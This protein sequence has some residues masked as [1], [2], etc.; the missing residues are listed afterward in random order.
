M[1]LPSDIALKMSVSVS[2]M[3]ISCCV[4]AY[5]SGV[6]LQNPHP[7]ETTDRCT[8]D[9]GKRLPDKRECACGPAETQPQVNL[10]MEHLP[11][12]VSGSSMISSLNA[13]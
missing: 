9:G 2:L 6:P 12:P 13:S 10:K 3:S 4:N 1:T 5:R 11:F 8:Q 7:S